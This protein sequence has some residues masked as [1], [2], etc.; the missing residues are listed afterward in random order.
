M[1]EDVLQL[2][3][4]LY[5]RADPQRGATP[6]ESHS[7]WTKLHELLAKHKI[8]IATVIEAL[9]RSERRRPDLPVYQNNNH[10]PRPATTPPPRQTQYGFE[11]GPRTWTW[12]DLP[13]FGVSQLYLQAN[14]RWYLNGAFVMWYFNPP[15][16]RQ[17]LYDHPSPGIHPGCATDKQLDA[18]VS[19]GIIRKS[20][21][22]KAAAS[23]LIALLVKRA[24]EKLATI[25]QLC[26]LSLALRWTPD[27]L[28]LKLTSRQASA[29]IRTLHSK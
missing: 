2:C 14:G 6:E 18:L 10:S 22:T 12:G 23:R 21:L 11:Y 5:A 25:D 27:E 29:R 20:V 17:K 24:E 19:F 26:T 15:D 16:Q 9:T 13:G 1:G 7:A 4:K 3:T 28:D 8:P